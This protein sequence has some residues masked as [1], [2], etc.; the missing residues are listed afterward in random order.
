MI[1][2]RPTA[3]HAVLIAAALLAAPPA[4]AADAD[5]VQEV[6]V[7]AT[8]LPTPIDLATDVQVVTA[9][10]I[11]LR[12]DS[13]AFDALSVVPGV[14]ISRT[15]AFGGL[16][17]VMIRGASSDK[18]L[19][20]VDGAPMNDPTSP[21]GGFDFSTLDLAEV[22]RIEVL[23]GPQASLWGSD[24]I[25]GVVAITTREPSGLRGSAEAGS[26]GSDRATASAGLA[27]TQ[28]AVGLSA[29]WI[30]SGGV[31]AA[32]AQ[33]GNTERDGFRTLTL[34]ANGRTQFG[35]LVSLDLR[36][37]Y[38]KAN[39]DLDSSGGPT[40]VMDGPDTQDAW[41]VSGFVR[42]RIKGPFGFTQELRADGM[43]MDRLSD[44]YFSGELF[45][46]EAK[47]RRIDYRWTA[48]RSDLGPNAVIVGVERQEDQENT[49]DGVQT[50]SNLAGFGVWRFSP[51]DRFS[52]TTSVR[53]DEPR[54]YKGVTTAR[55]SGVFKVGAGFSLSGAVGQGF[56]TPSIFQT[57]YPCFECTPPGPAPNLKPERATGWDATLAWA[58]PGGRL[59]AQA[60]LYRLGVRDEIDYILPR[61]YVNINRTRTTGVDV[62]AG[63]ALAYGFSL[64][65]SYDHADSRDLSTGLPLLRVPANSGSTSLAWREGRINAEV[66]LRAQGQASD[67]YGE[68]RPFKV[69]D[70]AAAYELNPHLS[71]TSRIE[72]LAD[73]HYQEAFGYGEPGFGLFVGIRISD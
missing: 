63:A 67:V 41:T 44:S 56:K 45:P 64:R 27:D 62:Q 55:V 20:L 4:R 47:G 60:T 3:M 7:I 29:A 16:T 19:V 66:T 69:V 31:S 23:E 33:D 50:S 39:T 57:T 28:Q 35:D 36:V 65:A 42:A 8:R 48:Q 1:F 14:E 49:G 21:A 30:R 43:D 2:P 12:Q 51:S 71:L 53:R 26:F 70:L 9:D 54:D 58:S 46:F 24:A 13:L 72:N 15:G 40:G 22:D 61:G 68:I 10:D 18:T 5:T 11:A 6:E 59:N 32:D 52:V 17:S 34:Q 38:N 73:V 37:R 25:G